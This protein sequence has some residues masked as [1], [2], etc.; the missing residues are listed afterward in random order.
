MR[1]TVIKDDSAVIIDGTYYEIDVGALP[2]GIHAIQWYETQGEI[3]WKNERGRMVRNEEISSITD[4]QW[5]IDA[6]N[7]KHAEE[8]AKLPA[9]P[10]SLNQI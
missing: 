8:L 10:I 1:L 5:I 9:S 3:E 4:Y 7:L 2:V 6:W